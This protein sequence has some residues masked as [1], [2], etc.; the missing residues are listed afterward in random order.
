MLNG[1]T[2]LLSSEASC[3]RLARRK[4]NAT[5]L[6][7]AITDEPLAGRVMIWV[8]SGTAAIFLQEGIVV[9][10]TSNRRARG[11][12]IFMTA[13]YYLT[14][15]GGGSLHGERLCKGANGGKRRDYLPSI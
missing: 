15:G 3:C 6:L 7:A 4:L 14:R 10:V 5:S 1:E 2:S 9:R 8:F 13:V 11:E 12:T